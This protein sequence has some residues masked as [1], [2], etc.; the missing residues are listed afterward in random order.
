MH[1]LF[2]QLAP[3]VN[4]AVDY[5]KNVV[6]KEFSDEVFSEYQV[7]TE[8]EVFRHELKDKLLSLIKNEFSNG[9]YTL[10]RYQAERKVIGDKLVSGDISAVMKFAVLG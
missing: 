7:Q 2:Q 3:L 5:A 1:P 8:A 4:T 10:E 6:Y 9:Q